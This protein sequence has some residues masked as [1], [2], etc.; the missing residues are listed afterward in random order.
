MCDSLLIQ[1]FQNYNPS[2]HPAYD[3]YESFFDYDPTTSVMQTYNPSYH[4][5][6][7]SLQSSNE[8]PYDPINSN[9]QQPITTIVNA[10]SSRSSAVRG[11]GRGGRG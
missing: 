7:D 3:P 10:M 2:I 5:P 9:A 1:N 8:E 6:Y 11:R 4:P